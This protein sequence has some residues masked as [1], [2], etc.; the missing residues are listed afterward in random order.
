MMHG[1]QR[2]S[3]SINGTYGWRSS[4]RRTYP[5][6]SAI[7]TMRNP[8]DRRLVSPTYTNASAL[9]VIAAS[10]SVCQ[11]YMTATAAGTANVVFT[12]TLSAD[13]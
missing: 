5:Q 3:Q 4:V 6:L 7:P 8:N 9:G 13:L 2:F 11:H 12:L 10:P 1:Y